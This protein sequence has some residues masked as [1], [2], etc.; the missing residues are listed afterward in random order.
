MLRIFVDADG[1]PVK[2]EVY[3]VARRHGLTVTVVANA[4]IRIPEEE[5]FTLVVVGDRLD[6]ADDWIAEHAERDDIV[7][8]ADIPLASR[9]LQKGVVVIDQ[10][11]GEFTE[12]NIGTALAGRE[13]SSHLRDLGNITGGPRP[14]SDRD[15]SRFLHR[16]DEAIRGVRRRNPGVKP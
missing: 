5:R 8:S 16:L 10:R 14:F 15:R 7:V 3:R 9:C 13:L 12:D 2:D 11:G 4:R 6:A 1:C